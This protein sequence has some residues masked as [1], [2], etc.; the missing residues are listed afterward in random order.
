MLKLKVVD[1]NY[2]YFIFHLNFHLNLFFNSIFRT[3]VR[4]KVIRSHCYISV[5]SDN[6]VTVIVT[7]HMI[8]IEGHRRF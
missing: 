6:T 1:S 7:S 4:V 3:R 2:F 8:Y 5:I